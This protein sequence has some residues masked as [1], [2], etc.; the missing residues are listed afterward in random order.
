MLT[1]SLFCEVTLVWQ[2]TV[3]I[4]ENSP[5]WIG[6]DFAGSHRDF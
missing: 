2:Y 3:I 1:L 6:A 5:V 4:K